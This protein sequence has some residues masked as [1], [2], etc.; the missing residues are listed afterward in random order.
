M[1]IIIK[2][3]R[4]SRTSLSPSSRGTISYPPV[5]QGFR[6]YHSTESLIL[7]LLSDVYRAIGCSQLAILSHGARLR[8]SILQAT[9]LYAAAN[10]HRLAHGCY[11]QFH[12][13]RT[14]ARS[15]SSAAI[16][17]RVHSF[18]IARKD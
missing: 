8:F 12:H 9:N 15:L 3:L 14:V 16:S 7:R 10:L 11:Y 6:K 2:Y 13:L 5:S 4:S 1:V 17:T 18:I